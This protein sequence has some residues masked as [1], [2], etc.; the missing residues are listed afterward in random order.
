MI[1][2]RNNAYSYPNP[3]RIA[4]CS[5]AGRYVACHHAAGTDHSIVAN[6]HT[7]QD[8]RAAADPDIA[9]NMH[10]PPEL[11]PGLTLISFSRVIGG[12]YLHPRANLRAI[13]DT[14]RNDIKD[15]AVEVEE[16]TFTQKD[17]EA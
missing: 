6:A 17:I 8:D 1:E 16:Y 7:R 4:E 14:D 15:H 12:K 10:R 9:P 2:T 3:R 11:E 5:A 13:T